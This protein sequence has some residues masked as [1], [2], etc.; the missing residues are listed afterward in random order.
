M[1]ASFDDDVAATPTQDARSAVSD[2]Q[3]LI[4]TACRRCCGRP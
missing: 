2:L 3:R 4:W 1:A